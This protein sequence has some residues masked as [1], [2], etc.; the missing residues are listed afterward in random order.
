MEGYVNAFINYLAIERGLAKNT[1]ESYGRDLKQF[2]NYMNDLNLEV[3]KDSNENMIQEY[4]KSLQTKGR[5]VS[6]ISRNIAA[7]KA[8]YQYLV[9]ENY[10]EN[11]PSQSLDT[12]K[13]EKK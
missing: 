12:P 10:L 4:L 11:D 6:T 5:A 7:I 2:Q 13:V 1:L 8:F 9:K 3:E